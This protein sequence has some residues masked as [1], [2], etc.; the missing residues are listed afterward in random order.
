MTPEDQKLKRMEYIA[1]MLHKYMFTEP[2]LTLED[3]AIVLANELESLVDFLK[4]YKK[5]LK[6]P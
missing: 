1:T 2:K 5:H 6:K 4:V 3:I